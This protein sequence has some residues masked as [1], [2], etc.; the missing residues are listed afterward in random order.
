VKGA[1]LTSHAVRGTAQELKE[2]FAPDPL[3]EEG[4]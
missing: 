2:H 3:L 4:G 1:G